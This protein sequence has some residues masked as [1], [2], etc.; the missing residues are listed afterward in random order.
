VTRRAAEHLRAHLAAPTAA[1]G[2][3]DADLGAL[4]RKLVVRAGELTGRTAIEFEIERL[5]LAL[6]RQDREIAAARR[7]GDGGIAALAAR[8]GEIQADLDRALDV[9]MNERAPTA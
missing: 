7:S 1:L 2:D 9:A 6:A 8:R 3:D 4:M 5:Q